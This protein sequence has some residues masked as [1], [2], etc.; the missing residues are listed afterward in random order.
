MNRTPSLLILFL[1]AI[2]LLSACVKPFQAPTPTPAATNTATRTPSPSPTASSTP[3][4]TPRPQPGDTTQTFIL[5]MDDNGYNH[6]F[7]YAPQKMAPVRLT[8][9]QW[10]DVSPAVNRDGTK[11]VFAS[12][13]NAYWDLYTLNL[14]DGQINRVTDTPD[15]DGNPAW[16][17]D[18]QWIIYES[19]SGDNMEIN[20]LSTTN[21][22]Q[23]IQLINDPALD[24]DPTWSPLGREVAFV[25]NRSG[26][27]EIWIA[28]LDKPDE[29]RF[30][31]ISQAPN[32]A[33][34]HPTWSPDGSKLAWA[35]RTT[36]QPDGIYVWDSAHPEQPA[37]RVGAGD[38][39][40]WN[41]TGDQI[42]TRLTG[43]NQ[44]YLMAYALDGTLDLPLTPVKGIRGLDWHLERATALLN[45]FYKQD[46][47][48]PTALW[49]KQV[50]LVEDAPGQRASIIKL[51]DVDAPHPYLHDAVNESFVALRAR[52]ILDTGWDALA[53]LE[54][55]YT[56]LTS[57]LDPGQ[58]QDWLFTGRAIAINP[59]TL[60]AGWMVVMREEIDGSTYWRIYLRTV[61]QDGSQGEP[62]RVLPWDLTSRYSLDP[63]A[64]DQGGSYASSIPTGFWIDFTATVQKYG[65]ERLPALDNWRTYFKGTLF[66]E[67]VL[68]DGLDWRTAMLQVYPPDI[69]ITPTVV[70]PPT[71]TATATPKGYR[72]KTA[73]PTVTF[74]AT[75][76]PTFT[77]PAP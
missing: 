41:A 38:W 26:D 45:I 31:N 68:S 74:T 71:R 27:D 66:N 61:A 60:N 54:N 6:L 36:G 28:N 8:N 3:T 63:S 18:D 10:D 70:I 32:S 34:T 51:Q 55:A 77:P 17:P 42:A 25:S 76:R 62:L 16:S 4:K 7:A 12:N 20:I 40:V 39:P 15:F 56:P 50:Q 44:D 33:D 37:V 48:T 5:S 65:W 67:F 30:V 46:Q 29:G 14:N 57:V 64:Y 49:Q 9:G 2:M 73:T 47:V 75:M 23:I 69:F 11:V 19:M 43:P 35:E 13:R 24:Q 59:L 21:A 52:I 53:S 72:Y 22:G 1:I 58:G